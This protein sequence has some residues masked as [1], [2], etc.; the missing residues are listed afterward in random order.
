MR[1]EIG[2]LRVWCILG[3]ALGAGAALLFGLSGCNTVTGL[4]RDIGGMFDGMAAVHES[5]GTS[6]RSRRDG[7]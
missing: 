7:N 4:G 6:V 1:R 3:V 2:N 5:N